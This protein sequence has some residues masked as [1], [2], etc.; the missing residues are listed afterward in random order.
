MI[1]ELKCVR[2]SV[3]VAIVSNRIECQ[4]LF[5]RSN[6]L[7]SFV[8]GLVTIIRMNRMMHTCTVA[9]VV[10]V[11]ASTSHHKQAGR[12]RCWSSDYFTLLDLCV[13]V[14]CMNNAIFHHKW[15][16][17]SWLC[18]MITCIRRQSVNIRFGRALIR[19]KS[20][21]IMI[22][23]HLR[24]IR[25]LHPSNKWGLFNGIIHV[26]ALLNHPNVWYS[27]NQRQ[28]GSAK[29]VANIKKCWF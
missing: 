11:A 15:Y 2:D 17:S 21:G 7:L 10:Y 22:S 5:F 29:V 28:R 27:H 3:W 23:K 1:E 18:V 9:Y 19:R 25:N 6:V 8:S 14:S 24:L 16:E 20:Q 26:H 12:I 4:V 13:C